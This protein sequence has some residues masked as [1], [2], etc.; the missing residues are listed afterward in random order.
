MKKV[1]AAVFVIFSIQLLI[2][3]AQFVHFEARQ[4]TMTAIACRQL[5]KHLRKN[6]MARGAMI[7]ALSNKPLTEE[8]LGEYVSISNVLE[9]Q[10]RNYADQCTIDTAL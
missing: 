6:T 5:V 7:N 9:R 4:S 3:D 1:F 2:A 8:M 10:N